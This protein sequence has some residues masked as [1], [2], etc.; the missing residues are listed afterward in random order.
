MKPGATLYKSKLPQY[1]LE[2]IR[3]FRKNPTDA[4]KLMWECLRARRLNG[5]KFRRQHPIGRY[6]VDFY[7]HDA[8]LVVEVDGDIHNV[9][10]QMEYDRIR[11]SELK[12]LDLSIIR[13]RNERVMN[14]TENVLEEIASHLLPSP[15]GRGVGGEGLGG[16][17]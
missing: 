2:L 6:V 1:L 14:E 15:V 13:F 17:G 3:E 16:E 8:K 9:P 10:D 7:C 4:E 12:A 11:E 5:F